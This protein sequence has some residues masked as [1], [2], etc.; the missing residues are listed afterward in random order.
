M[1]FSKSEIEFLAWQ[2][3]SWREE[4]CEPCRNGDRS[5]CA[6]TEKDFKAF[7]QEPNGKMHYYCFLGCVMLELSREERMG[8]GLKQFN[9][10]GHYEML[11]NTMVK[12]E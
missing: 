12:T 9:D 8:F 5:K 10:E 4:Q 6:C 2:E 1:K 7:R 11:R 3:E